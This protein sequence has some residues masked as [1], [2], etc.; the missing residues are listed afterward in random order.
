M[1]RHAVVVGGSL[2]GMLA[3]RVLAR[4][5]DRV[6]VIERDR[7]PEAADAYRSGA[8]QG[9]HIHVLLESGR[10]ALESLL[11]GTT[12]ELLDQGA[13]RVGIPED[14][15]QWQAGQWFRRTAAT[16]S[17][18]TGSRPRL[19]ALIRRRVLADPRIRVLAGTEAVGLLGD[20]T[21][22]RGVLVRER[23][24]SAPGESRPVGAALVVD[25]S[26]RGSRAPRWLAELGAE[27]PREETLDTGLAYASRV[28]RAT[29][30]GD[31]PDCLMQYV[32]PNPRQTV[33][34]VVAPAEEGR[35]IV[36]LSGLRGQEPPTD[37]EGFVEFARRLPHP[38][39][40]DWLRR[41]EPEPGSAVHGFRNT[42][43]IRRRYD[44]PGRRPG[45]FLA[46]GDA[47]CAFNPVYGQGMS[48]AAAN[49]VALR[50]A[51]STA[52]ARPG[53]RHVQRAVLE[54]SRQ[55][56][57]V[58]C[59]A[60]REMPGAVGDAARMS[61]LERPAAWYLARV[62]RRSAADPVVG[63]AFRGVLSLTAP[64]A[65]LFAPRIVRAVLLAPEPPAPA[66]P[67]REA[68]TR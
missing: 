42:A 22:V 7:Y 33:G 65:T 26:G 58:S 47:L 25:A 66:E 49:A 55:A 16:T 14:V 5:A 60:D 48:V 8:P 54:S 23:G 18:L 4:H 41:A 53:V 59:G 56:W 51:L 10:S 24:A 2:A 28:Y 37:E 64:V 11:P 27:P 17:V 12:R 9:R 20:A 1:T 50:D 46:T 3:A 44:E 63:A 52:G 21:R 36:T 38:L 67:P 30:E 62:Q 57:D 34:A 40:Y 6:T 68:E 35:W 32:V 29:G 39:V 61:P 15:V 31:G 43:N 19:E 13:P 45:G